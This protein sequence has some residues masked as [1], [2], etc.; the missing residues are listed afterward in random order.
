MVKSSNINTIIVDGTFRVIITK[1]NGTSVSTVNTLSFV[2]AILIRKGYF[3]Y[4]EPIMPNE[5]LLIPDKADINDCA[6]LRI[7]RDL[8]TYL[9][10]SCNIYTFIHEY[11]IA[12]GVGI[13]SSSEM[14]D[15][16]LF[17]GHAITGAGREIIKELLQ[18]NG[19]T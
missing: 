13:I 18:E 10:R 2:K 15:F 4:E 17:M 3:G 7:W 12:N 11:V 14:N 5:Y 6:L 1:R 16:D 19:G 8:D 9:D